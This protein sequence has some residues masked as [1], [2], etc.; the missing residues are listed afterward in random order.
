MI[1]YF[2]FAGIFILSC[3]DSAAEDQGNAR[4]SKP[5][6]I[7]ILGDD[8]GYETLGYKEVLNFHTPNLDALAHESTDFVN[9]DSQPLCV[10]TRV[11][12]ITGQ[13][14]YRNYTGWGSFELELPP[15]GKMMKAAGYATAAF[16]KWHLSKTPDQLGFDEFC[17]FN[18]SPGELSYAEFFKRYFYNCPLEENGGP[19]VADYAPDR[20]NERTLDFIEK[21]QDQPFF[22]YYPMSL[23]HNPFEPT[24]DS[25]DPSST[26][27]QQNF[28]DMV[29]YAD[30]MIGNVVQKL[31]E[32]GLYEN[33]I[34]IYTT[35]NG[36]KTLEHHMSNGEVIYGGKG[37]ASHDGVH[38]PLL[39]KYDGKRQTSDEL[40]DFTDF[41]PTLADLA[42]YD[43]SE[44]NKKLD[45]VS[46]LPVLDQEERV[47]KP[48]IFST[49][50]H[51]LST[52]IRD[53]EYKLYY[54]GR[55]YN[56]KED[57]RELH[58]FY[59]QNDS[60]ITAVTR[61]ILEG[62]F[63]N[64]FENS[65]LSKYP[66]K[67]KLM[68]KYGDYKR[69]RDKVMLGGYIYDNLEFTPQTKTIRID[70]SKFISST[71][72]VYQLRVARAYESSNSGLTYADVKIKHVKISKSGEVL[73]NLDSLSIELRTERDY[74]KLRESGNPIISFIK[75]GDNSVLDLGEFSKSETGTLEL[76]LEVELSNP[77]NQWGNR[78]MIYVLLDRMK[79]V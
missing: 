58:P 12:L 53:K 70:L 35:D 30:K 71:D 68:A 29:T 40:V 64:V 76:E 22:I 51:P 32:N 72:Q 65:E 45:G 13:Y 75:T 63:D 56:L 19:F 39:V 20:F 74:G 23:A 21:N 36:S 61:T 7:F 37:T 25:E 43:L 18:G 24:P 14:N 60:E 78:I 42:G 17:L 44:V 26:D 4:S 67:Q 59:K 16:G 66:T 2:I 55:L 10:P 79:A 62:E 34:I 3:W 48:Y 54:D 27:W 41:Y 50:F 28:E 46:L 1:K 52:Y 8:M 77:D 33:T 49:F 31:K 38:V 5:N 6:I 9:C 47:G 69:I 15:L 11:K 57:P 73:R